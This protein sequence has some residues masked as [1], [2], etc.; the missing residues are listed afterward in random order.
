MPTPVLSLRTIR[1]FVQHIHATPEE[2]FPLLCPELERAW[3]PGWDYRMIHSVSG[4]AERG[5]VFETPHAMGKTTW[6]LTEHL[7]AKRVAFARFQPD[8]VVAQ[9]DITL[10]RHHD[11]STAVCIEYTSTPTT[12]A[13]RAI[14]AKATE[15]EW[16]AQMAHWE[17]SMNE[18]FAKRPGRT[19]AVR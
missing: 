12:D 9:I 5:A 8:G 19:M 7:P 17:G 4:V 11:G 13:A 2:V 1:T 18:W 15:Q 14:L 10:G 3:L 6:M 16:L